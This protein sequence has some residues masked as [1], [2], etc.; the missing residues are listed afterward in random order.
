[1]A[2]VVIVSAARTP[3]GRFGGQFR[4]LKASTLGAVAVRAAVERAGIDP[5]E[6]DEIVLGHV[7]VNGENPNVA[8]LAWLEA[9]YPQEVPAYSVD[10]QCGSGLQAVINGALQIQ[11]GNAEIVVAGGAECESQAEFYTV[12]VRWGQRLGNAVLHDRIMRH[13]VTVSCPEVFPKMEGMIHTSAKLAAHYGITRQEADAWALRSHQRACAAIEQ[14]KF[15]DEIV[16]VPV[17]QRG[18]TVLVERDEHPRPDTSL[19]VLARL[20]ALVGDGIHTAGNASGINDA[21]AAVVLMSEAQ[22]RKRGLQPLASFRAYAAAGVDPTIMG[23][24]PV[25]A[26][27]RLLARTGLRLEELDLLEINEAFAAQVLSVLKELEVQDRERVNVN[28]SGISLGH[29]L[30]ATGARILCTL[31]F[32]MRRRG[33]RWGLESMCCGGGQGLAALF[34]RAQ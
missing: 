7:F 33:A 13:A 14:G 27:R 23:I 11:T 2:E 21:A 30:G 22:A 10:R 17:R 12:G 29:P 4:D 6:V 20:P 26:I 31:L 25:P 3:V 1:M 28:G 15:A 16:P 5:G 19:E 34:E 8:R 32:E 18:Q 9:G 24:G